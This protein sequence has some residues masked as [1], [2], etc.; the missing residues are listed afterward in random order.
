MEEAKRGCEGKTDGL[1]VG[2]ELEDCEPLS[3]VHCD[4]LQDA[5]HDIISILGL[6]S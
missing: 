4:E 3:V 2:A 1:R 5:G 6:G